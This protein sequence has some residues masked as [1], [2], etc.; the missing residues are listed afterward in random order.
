MIFTMAYSNPPSG[1]FP[2]KPEGPNDYVYLLTSRER[3]SWLKLWQVWAGA[4]L[5]VLLFAPVLW[6]AAHYGFDSFRFQL[7]RST[8]EHPETAGIGE[9]I[10]FLIETAIQTLPTLFVFP[11]LSA[12]PIK[13]QVWRF[14]SRWSSLCLRRH[15]LVFFV[16]LPRLISI[17]QNGLK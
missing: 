5:A 10:R 7:G 16:S 8:L 13:S 4:A 11:V 14:A 6:I 1:I 17:I 12:F 15:F 2:C 9:F 3:L